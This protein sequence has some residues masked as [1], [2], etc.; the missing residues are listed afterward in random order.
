ME[1]K[2][3]LPTHVPLSSAH[4]S[5]LVFS[6]CT[7]TI[8]LIHILRCPI[9][10]FCFCGRLSDHPPPHPIFIFNKST[11]RDTPLPYQSALSVPI[12]ASS[13]HFSRQGVSHWSRDIGCYPPH[14]LV[15][16][17]DSI[18][19]FSRY[20]QLSS[21]SFGL[22]L[23]KCSQCHMLCCCKHIFPPGI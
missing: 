3:D 17:H 23:M 6:N 7:H 20:S 2:W 12:F 22:Q 10:N 18:H 19:D 15:L 1:Y 8:N 16:L 9:Q 14:T 21:E 4:L 5:C 11:L 13:K